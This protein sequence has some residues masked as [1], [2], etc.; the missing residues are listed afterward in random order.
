MNHTPKGKTENCKVRRY[1][2]TM[3]SVGC[4]NDFLDTTLNVQYM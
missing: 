3:S 4:G 2:R 1:Q